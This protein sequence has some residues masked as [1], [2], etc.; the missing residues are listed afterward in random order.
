MVGKS[1]ISLSF[2][3][4]AIAAWLIVA[5]PLLFIAAF[6]AKRAALDTRGMAY[7]SAALSFAAA[8]AAGLF[9]ARSWQG[10]RLTCGVFCGGCITVILLMLGFII[11]GND[12]PSEGVLSVASFSLTGC[13]FGSVISRRG[14]RRKK[15]AI[16]VSRR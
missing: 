4:R 5:L 2:A 13:V 3:L 16:N 12:M 1:N 7:L 6:I 8:A 15:T 14:G 11:S 9:A 10:A